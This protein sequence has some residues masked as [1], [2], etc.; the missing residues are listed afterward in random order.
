[1]PTNHSTPWRPCGS[2]LP[3]YEVRLN[4]Q[5][6]REVRPNFGDAPL[7]IGQRIVWE[8]CGLL[9]W[10]DH[11][12]ALADKIDAA[13]AEGKRDTERL[14]WLE[15]LEAPLISQFGDPHP[16]WQ[17]WNAG[18]RHAAAFLRAAIDAAIGKP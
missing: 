12:K 6:Q 9:G 7:T 3:G 15:G 8:H 10:S 17:I 14:D 16:Q 18:K 2:H 11:Y 4:E 13:I 5:G 1:M